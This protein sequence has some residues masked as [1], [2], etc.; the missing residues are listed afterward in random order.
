M[1]PRI[2]DELVPIMTGLV[3][4]TNLMSSPK[5]GKQA[6]EQLDTEVI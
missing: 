3:Q 1:Q 2:E 4:C 5:A 6:A